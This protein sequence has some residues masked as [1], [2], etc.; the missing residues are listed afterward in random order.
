MT[1]ASELHTER[2]K[3]SLANAPPGL[4]WLALGLIASLLS[5]GGQWSLPLAAWAA[6]ILLL[7]FSRTNN[8]LIAIAGL[9]AASFVQMLWMGVE[10]GADLGGNAV[11]IVLT[12]VLGLF[13]TIPYVIDRLIAGRLAALGRV[14][15]FPAVWAA[16]EYIVSS[17]L[18]VGTSIGVRA[19]TQAENLPL[20]Q[21]IALT[22]PFSIGF[23]IALAATIA[24]HIWD[25]P[26]SV[27]L[28][29]FGGA[30]LA[31]LALV[32]GY[33]EMRLSAASRAAAAP[34]VKIAGITAPQSLRL[35][36]SR[37][38]TMA[39][40]PASPETQAAVAT[41]EMRALYARVADD[42]L[43]QTQ[44]AAAAGAQIIV[45]SETAAP[46]LEA[47]KPALLQRVAALARAE[48]VYINAAIGVPF[49]RNETYLFGPDGAQLWHYRKNHPVP[50]MEPVAPHVNPAPIVA[51]PLGR[52]ANVICFDGDFPAL[53]RIAADILLVPAW[54]WREIGYSHTMKMARL[55][56]VENGYA[57]V[58]VDFLGV[59]G[60]FDQYGR[61][62][63]MQ[64]TLPGQTHTLMVDA[65]AQRVP[66]LYNQIGDIF[67]WLCLAAALTL[68]AFAI[69]RPVRKS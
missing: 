37:R 13:F 4:A 52:L 6:P 47:D 12:F 14:F 28:V 51:T 3:L 55:R 61:T 10:W 48:G 58:R 32:V 67:A 9:A 63:A 46:V 19:V 53:T 31:L 15:L 60:A 25:N 35:E 49:E 30:F 18:P 66:T 7:R 33:G 39:N 27:S 41:P 23:L 36:A 54:D 45:W 29:R 56:A 64:D 69:A 20:L 38:V 21:I 59:S 2:Q 16:V 17:N 22:G 8:V 26:S 43:A 1:T 40:F 68:S 57:L 24:N 34:A 5:V 42:L 44:R 50:G 62:L 65:P 11:T